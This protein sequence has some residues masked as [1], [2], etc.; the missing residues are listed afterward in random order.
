MKWFK[1]WLQIDN[2]FEIWNLEFA[3]EYELILNSNCDTKSN[4]ES[5][6]CV[7][8]RDIHMSVRDM[9][10]IDDFLDIEI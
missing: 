9:I 4:H 2:E 1:I 8:A 3:I 5:N 6:V 10:L 7:S